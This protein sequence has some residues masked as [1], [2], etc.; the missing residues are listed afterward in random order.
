MKLKYCLPLTL[1]L[2]LAFDWINPFTSLNTSNFLV[3]QPKNVWAVLLPEILLGFIVAFIIDLEI[4]DLARLWLYSVTLW[5]VINW[6]IIVLLAWFL[7]V[8]CGLIHG[9]WIRVSGGE[10]YSFDL[11]VSIFTINYMLYFLLFFIFFGLIFLL[12]LGLGYLSRI[13]LEEM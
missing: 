5:Y 2:L 11:F 6:L 8:E 1:I 4:V 9:I 13:F 12:G 10:P 3:I 7:G